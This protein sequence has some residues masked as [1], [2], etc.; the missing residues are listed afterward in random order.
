MAIKK[1]EMAEHR[2]KWRQNLLRVF[3][4]AAFD[5]VALSSFCFS[6]L[7]YMVPDSIKSTI[8]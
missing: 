2:T 5:L 4:V 3:F 8:V 1:N 6:M 7:L